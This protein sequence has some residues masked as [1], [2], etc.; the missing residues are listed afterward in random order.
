MPTN[1]G[2]NISFQRVSKDT[3]KLLITQFP[4]SGMGYQIIKAKMVREDSKLF[5]VF[6]ATL[7]M[8]FEEYRVYQFNQLDYSLL[9]EDPFDAK[10]R[11]LNE[12]DVQE[13]SI[14]FWS[15]EKIAEKDKFPG[16]TY[17]EAAIKP[18]EDI[19][20]NEALPY[21]RFC[22]SKRDMR[23][24]KNGNFLPGTYATTFNDMHFVPSGF[25]A[26]GRY[27]L[28]NPASAQYVSQI[29][30][31]DRPN[32]MGTATP[33]FGQAG[34]G[35]EVLFSNSEGARIAIGESFRINAG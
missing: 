9:S 32:L 14:A 6:N 21:Y 15:L 7:I 22:A 29:I 20:P 24:G 13:F 27:A 30:T 23:V 28:P 1:R 16:L 18:H 2:E 25:A 4:E 33:N 11:D 5:L 17:N 26:V 8:P 34:G 12:L 3:Q 35:V 10:I 31:K 19:F